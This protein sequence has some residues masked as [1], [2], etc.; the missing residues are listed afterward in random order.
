M[1][2]LPLE[3]VY[4]TRCGEARAEAMQARLTTGLKPRRLW[5]AIS[6]N[7]SER[8]SRNVGFLRSHR[9]HQVFEAAIQGSSVGRDRAHDQVTAM[10][11]IAA[12]SAVHFQVSGRIPCLTLHRAHAPWVQRLRV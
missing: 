3:R 12:H 6:V 10:R 2:K 4:R 9:A 1:K 7:G 5:R 11:V 8:A